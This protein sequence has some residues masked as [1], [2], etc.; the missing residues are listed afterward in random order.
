MVTVLGWGNAFGAAPDVAGVG[1]GGRVVLATAA[2]AAHRPGA[3]VHA[4]ALLHRAAHR[5]RGTKPLL[6]PY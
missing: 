1:H 3:R 4:L 5:L 6:N 2:A